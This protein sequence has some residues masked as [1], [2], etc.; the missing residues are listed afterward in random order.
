MS[1]PYILLFHFV[2]QAH[3]A[4]SEQEILPPSATAGVFFPST[5]LSRS[6][7][8]LVTVVVAFSDPSP[9][10]D[11]ILEAGITQPNIQ[12]P[13]VTSVLNPRRDQ[14]PT[15]DI[16][17]FQDRIPCLDRHCAIQIQ[18]HMVEERDGLVVNYGAGVGGKDGGGSREADDAV[19][20]VGIAKKSE[21]EIDGY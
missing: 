7:T 2:A 6:L 12:I 19:L 1:S 14:T 21:V 10:N 11:G 17:L 20:E 16:N 5:S 13:L 4:S 9:A 3:C 18:T 8:L 15:L